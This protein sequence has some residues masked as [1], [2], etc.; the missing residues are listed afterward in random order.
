[1][2]TKYHCSQ[3]A[4]NVNKGLKSLF[5]QPNREATVNVSY[6][7]K[8]KSK[9]VEKRQNIAGWRNFALLT[10]LN[11]ALGW[12]IWQPA[13]KTFDGAA[14]SSLT[15]QLLRPLVTTWKIQKKTSLDKVIPI[16]QDWTSLKNYRHVLKNG[17][18]SEKKCL[19]K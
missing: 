14:L 18:I 9:H 1:M 7:P 13:R 6:W 5:T 17:K 3:K 11:K 2:V 4:L 15:G 16:E 12:Q 8:E 10:T 19:R